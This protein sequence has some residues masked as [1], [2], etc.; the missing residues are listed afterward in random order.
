[1]SNSYGSVHNLYNNQEYKT[2]VNYILCNNT[3]S[4][5]DGIVFPN[6]TTK[7]RELL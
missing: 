3:C 4:F 7:T 6:K 2:L 1:M 5:E